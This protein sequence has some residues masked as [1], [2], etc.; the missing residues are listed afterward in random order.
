[1][2]NLEIHFWKTYLT[3][4][5][6]VIAFVFHCFTCHIKF[7]TTKDSKSHRDRVTKLTSQP[8]VIPGYSRV[9]RKRDTAKGSDVAI[10]IWDD[11]KYT[12]QQVIDIEDHDQD[13]WWIKI[14][15]DN[16]MF[17]ATYYGEWEMTKEEW[18]KEEF[19]KLT[20]QATKI[21]TKWDADNRRHQCKTRSLKNNVTQRTSRNGEIM[22][23]FLKN[24]GLQP[25]SLTKERGVWTRENRHKPD[26]NSVKSYVRISPLMK[27]KPW[28]SKEENKRNTAP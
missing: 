5:R 6:F 21:T 23:E 17:V 27:H 12:C 14:Q 15:T 8:P 16:A 3:F 9:M 18:I 24:T 13:I 1:M 22:E 28:D 20:A 7:A 4:R 26:E 10:F 25:I 11:I 19:V 2:V